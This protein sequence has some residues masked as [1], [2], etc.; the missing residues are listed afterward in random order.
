MSRAN[1][2]SDGR[3]PIAVP[4]SADL[5]PA[6]PSWGS[7]NPDIGMQRDSAF[8]RPAVAEWAARRTKWVY[9]QT[10]QELESPALSD[11]DVRGYNQI[12]DTVEKDKGKDNIKLVILHLDNLRRSE[13]PTVAEGL[14]LRLKH[15][16][17]TRCERREAI[18]FPEVCFTG[19]PTRWS[20]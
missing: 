12:L 9:H 17:F 2:N 4:W 11:F 18:E 20:R 10:T 14:A 6:G 13:V 7:P 15:Y 16:G 5:I 8:V 19:P 1:Y 3:M